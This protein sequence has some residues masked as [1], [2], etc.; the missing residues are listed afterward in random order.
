MKRLVCLLFFFTVLSAA[1]IYAADNKVKFGIVGGLTSCNTSLD[2][3]LIELKTKQINQY[4]IGVTAYYPLGLGLSVQPSLQYAMK[5]ASL[6]DINELA[7]VNFK[8]GFL[9]LP[10]QVQWAP[11][12]TVVGVRP[13]VFAEPFVGYAIK[14]SSAVIFSGN[15][16]V[17]DSWDNIKSRAEG[18][19]GLG[20]GVLVFKSV[21][22]SARY[23][24]N[25]GTLYEY[26]WS[27]IKSTITGKP[28][29]ISASVS[30]LF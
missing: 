1:C 5:G 12:G 4:H 2:G 13:Y 16:T 10:V 29:G 15:S 21:Q 3:A 22:V 9:E 26:D 11:L 8:T 30:F 18:G 23:F 24:W 20:L 17:K 7:D 6:S 28:N 19:L 27:T 14:N 25:F